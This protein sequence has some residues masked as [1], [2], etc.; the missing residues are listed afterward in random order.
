MSGTN[1]IPPRGCRPR[2][3][4]WFRDALQSRCFQS[5]SASPAWADPGSQLRRFAPS[6]PGHVAPCRVRGMGG[7]H[8]RHIVGTLRG[9]PVGFRPDRNPIVGPLA[10]VHPRDRGLAVGATDDPWKP[11]YWLTFGAVAALT[12]N[13]ATLAAPW[14]TIRS[15]R[16]RC[17]QATSRPTAGPFVASF[18]PAG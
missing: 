16:I 14:R 1:V 6:L 7:H 8:G 12:I 17:I 13:A 4:L 9:T 15:G 18:G 10:R 11:P 5:R 2:S 3:E